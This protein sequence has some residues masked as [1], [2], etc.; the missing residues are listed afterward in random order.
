MNVLIVNHRLD[1]GGGGTSRKAVTLAGALRAAGCEV[2]L[3][4][5][6]FGPAPA[7]DAHE[8]TRYVRY[9]LGR[10]P[11]PAVWP[12]D[13][14]RDVAWADVVLLVNHWTTINAL[15]ALA[16]WRQARPVV[17]MPCGALPIF[18]R[19]AWLK[20]IYNAAIGRRIVATA[21]AAIAVTP[22]EAFDF[23]AYGLPAGRVQVIPNA[24]A[25]DEADHADPAR[26]RTRW[27]QP[28]P[29]VLFAG[30]L[31]E[32]KGPDLLLRAWERVAPATTLDL[33]L[34]GA[35]GDVADE[36]RSWLA[37]HGAR[38]RVRWLGALD[39]AALLDAFSAAHVLVVPSRSEAMSLVLL[40]AALT[41]CPV[42]ATTACGVPA[43]AEQG[44]LEVAPTDEAIAAALADAGAWPPAEARARGARL[45]D[46][47]R[48][49]HT[50]AAVTPRYVE[51]LARVA[52]QR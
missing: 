6:A 46:Y 14:S 8:R 27:S 26:F 51:V 48:A 3:A 12:A 16:A 50:W 9:A 19:S 28:G 18:G 43:V 13:V 49:T 35:P 23:D 24:V 21:A 33:V 34:A 47:V 29:F 10:W 52:G 30:R 36:V 15:Y 25:P 7:A 5:F 45:S 11:L 39:H 41:G 40:E 17:V 1:A 44:G 22:L 37:V 38:L 32:I 2:R 42:I 20:R 4:A 31:A